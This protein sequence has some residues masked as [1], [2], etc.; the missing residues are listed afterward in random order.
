MHVRD[1]AIQIGRSKSPPTWDV[2]NS[3]YGAHA[4]EAGRELWLQKKAGKFKTEAEYVKAMSTIQRKYA[5]KYP[6]L[7]VAS[8]NQVGNTALRHEFDETGKIINL[9]DVTDKPTPPKVATTPPKKRVPVDK[10]PGGISIVAKPRGVIDWDKLDKDPQGPGKMWQAISAKYPNTKF[11]RLSVPDHHDVRD[12]YETLDV[13]LA[14]YPNVRLD[15]VHTRDMPLGTSAVIELY[16]SGK[17]D[18]VLNADMLRNPDIERKM[19]RYAKQSGFH[20]DYDPERPWRYT[21]THEFGHVLDNSTIKPHD[22]ARGQKIDA[23][24]DFHNFVEGLHKKSGT[25][26][27]LASWLKGQ[28]NGYARHMDSAGPLVP[29]RSPFNS[30]EMLAEAFADVHINGAKA[31]PLNKPISDWLVDRY[32]THFNNGYKPATKRDYPVVVDKTPRRA[33]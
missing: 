4:K 23:Y 30:P 17:V 7:K 33:A 1:K 12:I 11:A 28:V 32:H 31:R 8:K 29:A 2:I 27:G 20:G 5:N 9:P 18:M 25:Q 21:V 13:L 6:H 10:T 19:N 22:S 3:T 26:Y 15:N 24:L 14:K 16:N